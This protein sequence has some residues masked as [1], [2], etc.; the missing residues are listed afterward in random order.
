MCDSQCFVVN[1]ITFVCFLVDHTGIVLENY[2]S[3]SLHSYSHSVRC[4]DRLPKNC[5]FRKTIWSIKPR[6]LKPFGIRRG[7]CGSGE[8]AKKDIIL[9]RAPL[10]LEVDWI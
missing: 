8:I 4:L 9:P 3:L 10:G 2:L 7:R 6:L 5:P 1:L